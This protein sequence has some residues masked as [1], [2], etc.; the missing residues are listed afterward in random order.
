MGFSIDTLPSA[1]FITEYAAQYDQIPIGFVKQCDDSFSGISSKEFYL[2]LLTGFANA[3]NMIN[4]VD[5][6]AKSANSL[7]M[8]MCYIAK[9]YKDI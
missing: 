9:K 2:G 5:P 6:T 4:Q 1:S 7:A 3:H 8:I